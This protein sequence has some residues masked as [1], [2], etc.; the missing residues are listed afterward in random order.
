LAVK[1]VLA[2]THIA[3]GVREALSA[4]GRSWDEAD[5]SASDIAYWELLRDLWAEGQTFYNVE[6]DVIVRPDTFDELEACPEPWCGFPVPYLGGEYPG[7]ACVKFSSE[8]IAACPDA[9]DRA[10]AMSNGNHPPK[11]WC[12]TDHFLQRVVLPLTGHRQHVHHPALGHYRD[13][14][15]IPQPSHGC[16]GT[17][18][19]ETE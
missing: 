13:Y 12:T 7:M 11:H 3:P 8:I 16:C 1:I 10:G 19:K 6:Q 5:V 4:T 2:F 17:R 18:V 9:L 15:E 14:G